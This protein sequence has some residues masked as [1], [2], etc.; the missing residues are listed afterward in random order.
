[1]AGDRRYGEDS[2]A[3]QAHLGILQAVISRMAANSANCKAWCITLV[4]AVLVIV[5]DKG[6]PNYALIALIP[7]ALFFSLDAY[8]LA[9]EKMFRD[10]YNAFIARLH[11]GQV[12]SEDLYAVRPGGSWGAAMA[13]AVTS[14]A[15]WPLYLTLATMISVAKEIVIK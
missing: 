15:V 11:A 14:F 13:D 2:P 6:K 12:T 5:A 3:V 4:S 7:T 9:L 8:Y 10:A 1:M